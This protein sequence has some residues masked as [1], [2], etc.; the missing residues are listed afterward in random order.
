MLVVLTDSSGYVK[1]GIGMKP[2]QFLHK[3]HWQPAVAVRYS[4]YK[5]H[6]LPGRSLNGMTA[7]I[8]ASTGDVPVCSVFLLPTMML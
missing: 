6:V 1:G 8:M 4:E 7:I 5:K 2:R 3:L